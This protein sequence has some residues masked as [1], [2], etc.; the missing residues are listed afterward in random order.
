MVAAGAAALATV[1]AASPLGAALVEAARL[2]VRGDAGALREAVLAA[3][4]WAPVVSIALMVL[5]AVVAPLPSSPVTYANGLVFGVWWGSLISWSGALL[6]AAICFGLGRRLG[7]PVVE[8]IVSRPALAAADAFLA[9]FG[10][11]AVLLGRLLP[12]VSFDVVS[13]AAGATRIPL[14]GFLVAT[15]IGMIPGTIL[16]SALGDL[17]GGSGRALLWTLAALTALGVLVGTLA[18]RL[19]RWLMARGSKGGRR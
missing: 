17:G 4:A 9:R 3:G 6:A 13:Y 10:T 14:P 19:G 1:V 16:Y 7:R 18:P 12:V 15:A 8:R 2:L 5:Q 11:R